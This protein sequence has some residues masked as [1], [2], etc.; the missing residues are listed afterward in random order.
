MANKPVAD[1]EQCGSC[2]LCYIEDVHD[3]IGVGRRFPPVVVIVNDGM[4]STQPSVNL[5]GWCGEFVQ[6][7]QS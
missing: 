7:C 5:D 4:E 6:R 1:V 3:D 2:K